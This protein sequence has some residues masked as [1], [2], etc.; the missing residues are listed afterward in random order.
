MNNCG[1]CLHFDAKRPTLPGMGHCTQERGYHR[2]ARSFSPAAQCNKAK[3]TPI[4][5]D[6]RK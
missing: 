6:R 4:P 1:K 5:G 3:F 2:I